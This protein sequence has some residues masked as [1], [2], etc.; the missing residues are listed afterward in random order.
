VRLRRWA[1]DQGRMVRMNFTSTPVCWAQC[2]SNR[3]M[4]KRQRRRWQLGLCQTLWKHHSMVFN[5]AFG[6]L[7][8]LSLPFQVAVE[9]LGAVVE[10]LG[11]V[12]ILLLVI[13]NPSRLRS[14]IPI[15]LLGLAC[16]AFLSVSAVV[17]EEMTHR[18]YRGAR[19]LATLLFY[20]LVENVGYRQLVLWYRFQGVMQ[21][22]T[23]FH[24]WEKVDHVG[25]GKS[26]RNQRERAA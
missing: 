19:N 9:A 17:L 4:L 2:P 5:P 21:F 18:R 11:Y 3:R 20:A 22:L 1:A 16:A 8:L 26:T 24:H 25:T 15:V 10:M 12:A 23:G 13:F 14:F 6:T 7:G